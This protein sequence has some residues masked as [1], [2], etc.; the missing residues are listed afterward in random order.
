FE[1]RILCHSLPK[2]FDDIPIVTYQNLFGNEANKI[3]QEL[4]RRE[5]ND[6]LKKY[7][8]EFQHYK[9]LYQTEI[10]IYLNSMFIHKRPQVI[11][12]ARK[13]SLN[14][15]QLDYLSKSGTQIPFFYSIIS[16]ANLF[17]S[18]H[19]LKCFLFHGP[20]YIRSN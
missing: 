5:F 20:N 1:Q 11:V 6:Q 16:I 19:V 8:L 9:D 7:E 14:R 4:K 2:T 17:L 12:D 15:L 18:I 10:N 13:I 3:M